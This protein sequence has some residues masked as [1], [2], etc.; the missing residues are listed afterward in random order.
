MCCV[1]RVPA[2]YDEDEVKSKRV[3][4]F[5]KLVNCILTLL[6]ILNKK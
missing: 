2:T 1:G 5:N 3:G 4:L 6:K